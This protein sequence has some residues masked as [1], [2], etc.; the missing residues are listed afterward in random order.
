MSDFTGNYTLA[1]LFSAD[2]WLLWSS[3][4]LVATALLIV[5]VMLLRRPVAH[6]FGP[7]LGYLL[8]LIPLARLFLPAFSQKVVIEAPVT[9][10]GSDIAGR[11]AAGASAQGRDLPPSGLAE[12]TVGVGLTDFDIWPVLMVVWLGGAAIFLIVELAIYLQQRREILVDARELRRIGDIRVIEVAGIEGPFAFGVLRRYIAV[13]V[14]FSLRYT[15]TEQHLALRH[16]LAHHRARDLWANFAAI[17]LL[18]LH[19][20][21]PLAWIAYRYFRFDQEAACDARVLASADAEER[22]QYSRLIAKAATG[23]TLALGSPLT[24]RNKLKERLI[25]MN[26]KPK[27]R[28]RHILGS[29]SMLGGTAAALA[30]TATVSYA[31]VVKPVKAV[32]P[33]PSV[34][35]AAMVAPVA[36]KPVA[37]VKPEAPTDTVVVELA[38]ADKK[39]VMIEREI[40]EKKAA[41]AEAKARAM[42]VKAQLSEAEVEAIR[43]E[44]EASARQAE[45][46]ARA[47][48]FESLEN[49]DVEAM[50]PEL[51]FSR[52]CSEGEETEKVT[53]SSKDG[54][55]LLRVRVC[56]AE[57]LAEARAGALEGL[58][59]ARDDIARETDIPEK[60][61]KKLMKT[62]D[63]QIARL[64]AERG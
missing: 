8:W 29:A 45:V 28:A 49:L 52:D 23:R 35:A 44:A 3:D 11:V 27:S 43:A 30:L 15:E 51:S 56:S 26:Q 13:P 22:A 1:H 37:V 24:P 41:R 16:E 47:M 50:I 55:T 7:Q 39:V 33:V 62:F 40:V 61:R 19:W 20:F 10:W 57:R 17:I 63:R 25:L 21:N 32:A 48:A 64:E 31:C 5:I 54:R 36:P 4:T 2:T 46:E 9:A 18:A 34:A 42:M 6:L 53:S 58:R 60:L 14:D 59:E 38:M 12:Q